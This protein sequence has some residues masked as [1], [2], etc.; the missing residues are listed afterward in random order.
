VGIH[1]PDGEEKRISFENQPTTL[2]SYLGTGIP[3]DGTHWRIT[4]WDLGTTEPG[5]SGSP[6]Y[7][8]QHQVVGQLHGGYAACGNDDSDWYGAFHV[9]WTGGGS[10][11]TR[12]S[13]WLDPLGTGE[14]A[15]DTLSPFGINVSPTSNV[16]HEGLL[17]GPFSNN[18]TQYSLN[19]Q[20]GST[21]N[22]TV[23]LGA[24][25]APLLLNGSTSPIN[26]SLVNGASTTVTV[27]LASSATSLPSG[28]YT[29]EVI[30][31]DTT[32]NIDTIVVH[33]LEIGTT[34]F[35]VSPSEGLVTGGQEG[36][37]F[38]GSRQYTVTNERPSPVQ[39]SVT[40]NQSWISINGGSS[41]TLNLNG[42]GDSANVTVS[43][44]NA[45]ASSL[46]V[47]AYS[48]TVN[49]TNQNGGDGD[50]TR[51]VTLEVGSV[52]YSA[53]GLPASIPDGS[54]FGGPGELTRTLFISDTFN[55]GDL[56]VEIDI[57][58][59]WI[60]DLEVTVT[61][62]HGTSVRLH[63]R[64]GDDSDDIVGTYDD[65][66]SL[67]PDGPGVL[68][69][70]NGESVNGTWTLYITDN[71]SQDTGSLNVW[72]LKIVPEVVVVPCPWDTTND[73]E[74][75]TD[76]FFALLQNWGPCPATCPWDTNDDNEVGVDDFFALLQN[77]GSCP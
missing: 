44:N 10:N 20:S 53:T 46:G 12:L 56:D 38:A 77:W 48:G 61:S 43:I 52:T 42:D 5:S 62:P 25:T 69:D 17:G 22:Y 31:A 76:D 39:V 8:P 9:S 40:S 66:G 64:T 15:I 11:T 63:N 71:A 27:S 2:T 16:L 32:N 34:N 73:G 30:F 50:T 29:R 6:I 23:T 14:V 18:P 54:W 57:S 3:G 70:F 55:I 1:H 59:T 7:N 45:V 51:P 26:S 13:N 47:G 37:P 28:T 41:A 60:S 72:N 36:G 33:T 19:N 67:T 24:G 74:V 4:D 68:S 21:A 35:S 65:D 75:G 58:H 49:F